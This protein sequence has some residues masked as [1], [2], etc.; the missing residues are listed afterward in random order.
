M[1]IKTASEQP[2]KRQIRLQINTEA[3]KRWQKKLF[4]AAN[5]LQKLAHPLGP[6]I[7]M[8]AKTDDPA[9]QMRIWYLRLCNPRHKKNGLWMPARRSVQPTKNHYNVMT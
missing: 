4:R 2:T 3:T 9:T 6:S 5:E 8:P 1:K 7:R